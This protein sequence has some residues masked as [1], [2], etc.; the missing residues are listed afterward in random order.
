[1]SSPL[2]QSCGAGTNI[3]TEAVANASP[4]GYTFLLATSANAIHA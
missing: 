3:A 4:D 2:D 1:M